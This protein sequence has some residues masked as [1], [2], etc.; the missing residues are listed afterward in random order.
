[1][2]RSRGLD[3]LPDSVRDE[4]GRQGATF[5]N[6]YR[7]ERF[8]L[9]WHGDPIEELEAGHD[10]PHRVLLERLAPQQQIPPD[11]LLGQLIGSETI[12]FREMSDSGQI[13][14]DRFGLLA[15][16]DQV[17]AELLGESRSKAV[18]RGLFLTDVAFLAGI[19]STPKRERSGTDVG[20]YLQ[21]CHLIPAAK[22]LT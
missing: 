5:G 14:L 19:V 21:I 3:Q 7:L 10:R 16:E 1:M 17:I 13:S 6:P 8:P 2:R 11:L 9:A 4:D 15:V 18:G 12:V 20:S 22:R